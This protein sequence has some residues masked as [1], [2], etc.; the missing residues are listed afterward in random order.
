MK[1]S[2]QTARVAGLYWLQLQLFWKWIVDQG[3][4]EKVMVVV[5]HEFSRTPFNSRNLK[6]MV[7]TNKGE[8]EFNSPGTDHHPV[9]GLYFLSGK[10]T[11]GHRYGGILDGYT[12][13]G[14]ASLNGTP[15]KE[16]AAPTTLQAVGTMLFRHWPEFIYPGQEGSPRRV[17]S[18]WQKFE[19]S[20]LI[21]PLMET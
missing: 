8:L 1:P 20:D 5:T 10:I 18:I 2:S 3:L 21:A 13:A 17:R 11:Q 16:I 6:T 7:S 15:S 4:S 12:A 19:D 9:N 14:S